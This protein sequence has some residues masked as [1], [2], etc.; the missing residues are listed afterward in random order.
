MGKVIS[1]NG[2]KLEAESSNSTFILKT[3]THDYLI[4]YTTAVR[5]KTKTQIK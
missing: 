2:P 3:S 5:T 4:R 1:I